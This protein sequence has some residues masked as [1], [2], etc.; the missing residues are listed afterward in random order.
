MEK[1]MVMAEC[2]YVERIVGSVERHRITLYTE[3]RFFGLYK[4]RDI[5]PR[6]ASGDIP[7]VPR[8]VREV[9]TEE[10]AIGASEEAI[11]VFRVSGYYTRL[12]IRQ[13]RIGIH[14]V[15]AGCSY[16]DDVR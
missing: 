6:S 11:D 14:S 13:W 3:N 2:E 9:V 4:I 12:W 1:F 15:G 7:R 8:R 10:V 5:G 16:R